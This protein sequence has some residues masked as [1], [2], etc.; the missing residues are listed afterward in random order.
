MPDAE[1]TDPDCKEAAPEDHGRAT[2]G[3]QLAGG[4]RRGKVDPAACNLHGAGEH[5][6][7]RPRRRCDPVEAE[8]VAAG[9][10]EPRRGSCRCDEIARD[11]LRKAAGAENEDVAGVVAHGLLAP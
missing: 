3:E 4:F 11:A 1:I 10:G 7:A 6:G 5:V 8:P 2:D 9:D